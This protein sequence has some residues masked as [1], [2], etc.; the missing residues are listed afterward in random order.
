M[1]SAKDMQ[2]ESAGV[3]RPSGLLFV[4]TGPSGVGKSSLARG[5][6][7]RVA[8]LQMSISHTTRPARAGEQDGREY[9]F[10]D[11]DAFRRLEAEQRMLET[12]TVFG[13]RY[14]TSGAWVEG[15][16]EAGV[17]V[18]LEIDW[19]GA[20]QI[21][22]RAPDAI[23]VQILPPSLAALEERLR[24]RGQD[25]ADSMAER[26]GK[27]AAEISHYEGFDYLVVNEQFEDALGE[28]VA[29]VTAERARTHVRA[30]TLAP[31][32]GRLLPPSRT[33]SSAD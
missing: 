30:N 19:Q 29:I 26:V 13:H 25:D 23:M 15:R 14:G 22:A 6:I 2:D 20:R 9:H 24:E 16:R 33:A 3:N 5:L 21:R 1:N 17:D 32:L 27:A 7:G 4:V 8:G 10:V 12:A 31:L 11:E 28:L 18:L